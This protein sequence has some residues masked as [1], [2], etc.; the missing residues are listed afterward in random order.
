[1]AKAL[2]IASSQFSVSIGV[3]KDDKDIGPFMN[4]KS[5][6]KQKV[7]IKDTLAKGADLL[8]G[9]KRHEPGPLFFEPTVLAD[10]PQDALI[11]HEETFGPVAA[12]MLL[13]NEEEVVRCTNNMEYSLVAYLHSEDSR[14]IYRVTRALQ[15][16]M[17]A[18]NRTNDIGVTIPFGGVKQ[19][20][21]DRKGSRLG[22]EA[23]TKVKYVCCD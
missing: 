11:C 10:V 2:K 21:L 13:D 17:I 9:G 14:R 20:G 18:V 6:A 22:L 12:L 7:Q 16:G 4:E 1:M 15:F 5:L 23:F 3:G 8:C 19:S